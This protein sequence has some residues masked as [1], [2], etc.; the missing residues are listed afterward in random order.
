LTCYS[1]IEI[2]QKILA[3]KCNKC[4]TIFKNQQI[5][6]DFPQFDQTPIL[7]DLQHCFTE[8]GVHFK[9]FLKKYD[10]MPCTNKDLLEFTKNSLHYRPAKI[11][12]Q[13]NELSIIGFDYNG[14]Y[15]SCMKLPLWG[16]YGM[17]FK[18]HSTNKNMILNKTEFSKIN[19]VN[20]DNCH[21]YIKDMKLLQNE[22]IYTNLFLSELKRYYAQFEITETALCLD[23]LNEIKFPPNK[24]ITNAMLGRFM[25][26]GECNILES[27]QTKND[28]EFKVAVFNF[29]SRLLISDCRSL[30]LSTIN[31]CR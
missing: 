20:L 8:V 26:S 21:T 3:F 22:C 9:M 27:I 31:N 12:C 30:I 2:Q 19:N 6:L 28:N 1:S 10:F 24:Y 15:R 14:S 5:Y 18:V 7:E 23:N 11:Y 25:T 29:F 17:F 4:E 16:K 13:Q